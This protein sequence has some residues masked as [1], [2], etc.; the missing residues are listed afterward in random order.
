MG[1]MEGDLVSVEG[2]W[3]F[4]V[5]GNPTWGQGRL[6]TAQHTRQLL[7]ELELLWRAN[8][9]ACAGLRGK[10]WARVKSKTWVIS[11][12]RRPNVWVLKVGP[13]VHDTGQRFSQCEAD[14]EL[15]QVMLK[16][17]PVSRTPLQSF[18]EHTAH[19]LH[20]NF[21]SALQHSQHGW[22]ESSCW[23]RVFACLCCHCAPSW[24]RVFLFL[25]KYQN[26]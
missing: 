14:L 8:E 13:W 22:T 5:W 2:V 6:P 26:L 20:W 21:S 18:A 10:R 12:W 24:L 4:L 1:V 25:K 23:A 3:L 17:C 11:K 15:L 9:A 19:G 16:V 7:Q